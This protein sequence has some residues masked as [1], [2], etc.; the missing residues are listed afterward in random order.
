MKP[1]TKWL[2]AII[3]LLAINMIAAIVLMV[4]ANGSDQSRVLPSYKTEAR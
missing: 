3:G 2:I 1:G 4:V